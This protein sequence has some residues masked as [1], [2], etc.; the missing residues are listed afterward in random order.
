MHLQLDVINYNRN[1]TVRLKDKRF[2]WVVEAVERLPKIPDFKPSPEMS[3]QD[4]W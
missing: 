3:R 1:Y 2:W 4:I